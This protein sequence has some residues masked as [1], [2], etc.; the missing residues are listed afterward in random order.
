MTAPVEIGVIVVVVGL[1]IVRRLIGEPA[2]ARR[3][4]LVPAALCLAGLSDLG[5]VA[6]SPLSVGFLLGI[7]VV[8]VVLGVLRGASVRVHKRDD[9]VFMRYT[10]TTVV[11][12]VAN[13]G[14]KV[15]SGLL[16]G[17]IDPRAEHAVSSGL[18]LTLG[19]GML[20]EGVAILS[21]ALRTGGRIAW[22]GGAGQK[23]VVGLQASNLEGQEE[24]GTAEPSWSPS[25]RRSALS[26]LLDDV[27]DL[28]ARRDGAWR[29]ERDRSSDR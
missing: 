24:H 12:F 8:S 11:L 19:V 23:Y 6:Q 7:S 22:G 18:A 29:P 5:Q 27:R 3:M 28:G 16:L 14:V 13:L 21:K 10:M 4:L 25:K 2:D 1:L 26:A 9:V 17:Y 15:G 20:A